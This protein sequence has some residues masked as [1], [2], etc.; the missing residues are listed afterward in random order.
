M[1]ALKQPVITGHIRLFAAAFE[2]S[3]QDVGGLRDRHTDTEMRRQTG[4]CQA[5]TYGRSVGHVSAFNVCTAYIHRCLMERCYCPMRC[6]ARFAQPIV[7]RTCAALTLL[8]IARVVFLL[9]A[10]PFGKHLS[11]IAKQHR[12]SRRLRIWQEN[13]A[14]LLSERALMWW[15]LRGLGAVG[16]PCC[17]DI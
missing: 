5:H 4:Q 3:S 10:S 13:L 11:S 12:V 6:N 1:R 17:W 14:R 2:W 7:D 9:A 8:L 15:Q 16:E